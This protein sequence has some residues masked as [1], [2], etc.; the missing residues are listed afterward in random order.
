MPNIWLCDF[1]KTAYL[2]KIGSQIIG[3]N[4]PHQSNCKI[5]KTILEAI[6]GIIFV[7][8][9]QACLACPNNKEPRSERIELFYLFV[10]C[11][12]KSM[13]TTAFSCSFSWV[14]YGMSKFSEITN[15][16]YLWKELSHF[17]D[18]LHIVRH[19]LKLQK[20]AILGWQCQTWALS[21]SDCQIF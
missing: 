5:F 19:P 10:A 21:Q 18:F 20:Y 3:Q 7:G 14:L 6:S 1:V 4:T 13:E 11:S 16:Q 9:D 12:Y 2:E 17:V 8:C 15:C